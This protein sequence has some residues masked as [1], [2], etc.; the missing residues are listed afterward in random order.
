MDRNKFISHRAPETAAILK[1]IP[2]SALRWGMFFMSL[3]VA[4]V[5][6]AS[7]HLIYFDY[8]EEI[9][10]YQIDSKNLRINQLTL[11]S[12]DLNKITHISIGNQTLK[13]DKDFQ[14]IMVPEKPIVIE[15]LTYRLDLKKENEFKIKIQ[16]KESLSKIIIG[17]LFN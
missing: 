17:D 13:K 14:F 10:V 8:D 3:L 11:K 16:K 2:G 15:F 5:I 9:D 7:I 1:T 4:L 6:Y 12:K